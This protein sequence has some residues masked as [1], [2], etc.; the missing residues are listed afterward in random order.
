MKPM[1]LPPLPGLSG[2]SPALA[3]GSLPC[4]LPPRERLRFAGLELGLGLGDACAT[5]LLGVLLG[6]LPAG[7]AGTAASA[8][9]LLPVSGS[10]A[11]LVLSGDATSAASSAGPSPSPAPRSVPAPVPR[12][13][14][15]TAALST[16]LRSSST[17]ASV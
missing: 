14:A 7:A 5:R 12:A 1:A 16:F 6:A 2:G 4:F 10:G 3:V 8:S 11:S 9:A 13:S 15:T 17:M